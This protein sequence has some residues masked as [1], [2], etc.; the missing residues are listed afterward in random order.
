M[1]L[2][3]QEVA[4]LLS[5][6]EKTIKRWIKKEGMPAYRI[7][8]QLYFNRSEAAEWLLE[9]NKAVQADI[10]KL[11]A[12][13]K[14]V[15]IHDLV[16]RGGI[17]RNIGGNSPSTVIDH[18]VREI[19]IPGETSREEIR[20]TLLQREEMMSTAVGNGIA[21]PHPRNPVISNIGDEAV[22]IAFLAEP[23]DF[24]ALDGKPVHTL[25]AVISSNARRHLEILARL[26]YLCR[27]PDFIASLEERHGDSALLKSI[28]LIEKEMVSA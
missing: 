23:A 5:A 3:I 13:E 26:S 9:N 14:P 22:S 10:E 11:F 27:R 20:K 1:D 8:K 25:F 19:N 18:L 2:K 4:G 24:H 6:P 17:F 21:I 28:E 15:S 7:K 12:A 16:I